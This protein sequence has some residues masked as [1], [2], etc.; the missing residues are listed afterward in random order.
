[1]LI[2]IERILTNVHKNGRCTTQRNRVCGRDESKGRHDDLVAGHEVGENA[3]HFQRCG[4]RVCEQSALDSQ[5]GSEPRLTL[6]RKIAVPGEFAPV[7]SFLEEAEFAPCN[8]WTV[9]WHDQ[10]FGSSMT[11]VPD[12]ALVS[13]WRDGSGFHV[14]KLCR[15]C[16]VGQADVS[17][18]SIKPDG[19]SS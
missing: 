7:D 3:G 1:M 19:G 15:V 13:R 4:A 12:G 16:L 8:R 14:P 18:I 10:R 6:F 17:A 2:E 5:S 11:V 9:K